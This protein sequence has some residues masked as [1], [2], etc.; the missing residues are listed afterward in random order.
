MMFLSY[1]NNI[2][3]PKFIDYSRFSLISIIPKK[4]SSVCKLYKRNNPNNYEYTCIVAST[5]AMNKFTKR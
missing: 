1:S 3:F 5:L 4:I 2:D